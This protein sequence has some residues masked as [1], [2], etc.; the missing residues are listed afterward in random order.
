MHAE[1][2]AQVAGRQGR[3]VRVAHRTQRRAIEIGHAAGSL[4]FGIQDGPVA[5]EAVRGGP[6]AALKD[7]D[8]ILIDAET[9]KLEVKLDAKE[10][11]SR[12]K[13]WSEPPPRYRSG[14]LGKYSRLVSSAAQ[15]AVCG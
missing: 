6:I 12:L 8:V 2:G 7:G 1:C 13:S 9:G 10:I 15:G 14:A 3:Q 11:E 4:Y 5:P